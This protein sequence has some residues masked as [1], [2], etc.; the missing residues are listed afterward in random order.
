MKPLERFTVPT[1]YDLDG[2]GSL[3]MVKNKDTDKPEYYVQKSQDPDV[4]DWERVG[5]LLERLLESY[6]KD[7][8]FLQEC[9][10]QESLE[11]KDFVMLANLLKIK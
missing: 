7:I 1:R 4:A 9:L 2:Y 6:I 8:V 5:L 3:C 10:L 11:K